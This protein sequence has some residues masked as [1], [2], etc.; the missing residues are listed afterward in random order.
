MGKIKEIF[1]VV[2]DKEDTEEDDVDKEL[3]DELNDQIREELRRA[4]LAKIRTYRIKTSTGL[5]SCLR[6]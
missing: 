4:K 3:K 2:D 6:S 5:R 1:G